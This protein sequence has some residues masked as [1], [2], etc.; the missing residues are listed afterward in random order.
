MQSPLACGLSVCLDA[1][2]ARLCLQ[3]TMNVSQFH[4]AGT[5]F[6]P[7]RARRGLLEREMPASG[8]AV[9]S[10]GNICGSDGTAAGS[11]VNTAFHPVNFNAARSRTHPNAGADLG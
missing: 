3:G 7:Y 11:C 9:K 1:S 8:L 10:S 6:G 5:G 4:C 2:T